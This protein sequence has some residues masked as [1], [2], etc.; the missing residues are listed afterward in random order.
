MNVS[1][2]KVSKKIR[3][4][5]KVL[6]IAGNSKGQ[7]GTVIRSIGEKVLVQGINMCKKHVKRSEQHPKGG[8]IEMERPVHI[9]NVAPCDAAGNRVKLQIVQA[10]DGDK[11]L[12]YEKD[13]QTS[14]WRSMKR[15]KE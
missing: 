9:S 2:R 8:V 1:K 4:G 3:A 14:T 10:K 12:V 6:V 15:S 7:N 11:E 13:G 5:D